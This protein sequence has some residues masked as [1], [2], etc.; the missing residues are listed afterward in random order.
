VSK[1]RQLRYLPAVGSRLLALAFLALLVA[2]GASLIGGCDAPDPAW[3]NFFS[4]VGT[5]LAV[6]VALFL[7]HLRALLSPPNLR[8]SLRE[9]VDAGE[10]VEVVEGKEHRTPIWWFHLRV[11]NKRRRVPVHGV[12]VILSRI[13]DDARKMIWD[14]EIP[15]LWALRH[16]EKD[17]TIGPTALADLCGFYKDR[18]TQRGLNQGLVIL[19]QPAGMGSRNP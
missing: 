18:R 4:A 15:M 9:T 5:C 13:E 12:R 8:L 2:V 11:E 16:D 3:V 14:G 1:R 17:R 6:V 19:L 7:D 10:D